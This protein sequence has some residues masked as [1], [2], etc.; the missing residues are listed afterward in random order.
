MRHSDNEAVTPESSLR[1]AW[2][3]LGLPGHPLPVLVAYASHRSP[4]TDALHAKLRLLLQ[5][6]EAARNTPREGRGEPQRIGA[7]LVQEKVG[8]GGMGVVYRGRHMLDELA[9]GDRATVAIKVLHQ[10]LAKQPAIVNRFLSE[11][12]ALGQLSHPNIVRIFDFI[13]D[14]EQTALVMEWL[15]GRNLAEVIGKE[16]GPIPWTRAKPWLE[17]L[18]DAVAYANEAGVIH[19]DLKPENVRVLPNDDLRVL[20]FGIARVASNRGKTQAGTGLGTL[21]YMAPEQYTDAAGVD[22]RADVYAL[23]MTVYEMLAGRLPWD[24][25]LPEYQLMQT[26][27]AGDIPPPTHFYPAIPSHVLE[28]IMLA[29]RVDPHERHK[30]VRAFAHALDLALP[31]AEAVP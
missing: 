21:D 27:A 9:V 1:E 25:S 19:R 15:E 23:G 20:D 14:G 30:S 18:F 24:P 10:H 29:L 13:R 4:S 28:A 7:Y 26:K 8:E 2:S 3:R 11:A 31:H 6:T 12:E 17:K 22:Q 16:T 5:R